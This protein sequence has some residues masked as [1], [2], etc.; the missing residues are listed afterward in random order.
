[1]ILIRKPRRRLHKVGKSWRHLGAWHTK[2]TD[3]IG[4]TYMRIR[5]YRAETWWT[6]LRPDNLEGC[7][8]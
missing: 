4:N 5:R 2:F 1:M 7:E 8:D 6:A 3:R